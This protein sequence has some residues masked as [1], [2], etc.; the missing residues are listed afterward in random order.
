MIQ[1]FMGELLNPHR[2]RQRLLKPRPRQGG[3]A[4]AAA[5]RACALLGRRGMAQCRCLFGPR[6]VAGLPT[7]AHVAAKGAE[8]GEAAALEAGAERDAAAAWERCAVVVGLHPDQARPAP[9]LIA[10]QDQHMLCIS[11]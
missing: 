8:D 6:V 1:D 11:S 2:H 7:H 3:D 10:Y 9:S 4:A 5:A